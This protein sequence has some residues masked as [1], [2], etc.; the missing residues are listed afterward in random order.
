MM[1]DP[2]YQR[3]VTALEPFAKF[4]E[5]WDEKPLSRMA[6]ELYGIHVGTEWEA[7]ISLSDCRRAKAALAL[8]APPP[9][10][11]PPHDRTAQLVEALRFAQGAIQ[12]AICLEEGL[13]GL[14]GEAV[15]KMIRAAL[16]APPDDPEAHPRE[17]DDILRECGMDGHKWAKAFMR[18]FAE[19]R[20]TNTVVGTPDSGT[21]DEGDMIAW[22][23]NAIMA[24]YDE[25]Q[26]RAGEARTPPDPPHVRDDYREVWLSGWRAGRAHMS[27]EA[28]TAPEPAQEPQG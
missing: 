18:Q 3:L 16:A 9:P 4:A 11:E 5:K 25:A 12:D 2:V 1:S 6:D 22:F 14:A 26:R 10:D 24:G 27:G 15:L 19:K 23:C 21:V 28:R 17:D 8:L 7:T 13:D 20:I